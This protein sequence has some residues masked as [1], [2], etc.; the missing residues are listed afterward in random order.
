M[1]PKRF[2][3]IALMS[4]LSIH[5]FQLHLGVIQTN[6][7][8]QLTNGNPKQKNCEKTSLL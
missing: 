4:Q 7:K 8:I 2:K 5:Q 6:K 1:A 3:I